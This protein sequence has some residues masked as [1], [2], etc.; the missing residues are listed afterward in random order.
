[1]SG[2]PLIAS[3]A[4]YLSAPCPDDDRPIEG[5][6]G[7]VDVGRGGALRRA[8]RESRASK[9]GPRSSAGRRPPQ[10]RQSRYGPT[11]GREG[12]VTD[13][14]DE[15]KGWFTGDRP[16]TDDEA[17][18]LA[19]LRERASAWSLP[20][21]RPDGSW[22]LAS[23][24]PLFLWVDHP[25]LAGEVGLTSLHIGYWP[26]TSKGLRLQGEWG[27]NHLLDNGGDD[28][29]LRVQG[30]T[31]EPEFFAD[32]AATWIETQL[33]RPIERMEWLDGDRV[34]ASRIRLAGGGQTLTRRG[35]WLRT[36]R[37]PDRTTRLN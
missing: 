33:L 1:M 31:G 25:C 16:R 26:L 34:A 21:L 22:C 7:T 15:A 27:D 37:H 6:G 11:Q 29:D 13:T 19:R 2:R 4:N 5:D 20:G 14:S 8:C 23:L 12:Q 35:S 9:Q 10:Q 32:A 3:F 18:F 30:I 17:R 36:R 28:T 24:V